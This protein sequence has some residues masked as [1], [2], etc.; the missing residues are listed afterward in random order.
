MSGVPAVSLAGAWVCHNWVEEI[1]SMDPGGIWC[2]TCEKVTYESVRRL[3][4]DPEG[5]DWACGSTG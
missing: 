1:P 3:L 4:E 5:D 2:I